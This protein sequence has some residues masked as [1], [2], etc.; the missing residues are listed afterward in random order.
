MAKRG[1]RFIDLSGQIFGRLT[2]LNCEGPAKNRI[3]TWRCAC[4]CGNEVVCRGDHLR[5]G[6]I[7][8][9]G[10]LNQENRSTNTRTHGDRHT[11]LY[12][13]WTHMKQR[14]KNQN[15]DNFKH[16]GGRGIKL[17]SEWEKDFTAFRD[18]AMANG[19][20]DDLTIDRND[21]D[22]PYSPENCRWATKE[23]QANNT[24]RNHRI[25]V[26]GEELTIA[27]AAKIY[28]VN[29][30]TLQQ[31]ISRGVTPEEAIK[32]GGGNG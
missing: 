7:L 27:E 5:S 30:D 16:Y 29:Y 12:N 19:Y 22:G 15:R 13:I 1:N 6:K 14:C 31:R 3:M 32:G 11:R 2:V 9:C 18:W 8:S 20:R 23:D 25:S 26:Y 28:G 21:G 17:C 24:R 10:C 4:S